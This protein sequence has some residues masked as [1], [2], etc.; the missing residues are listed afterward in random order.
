MHLETLEGVLGTPSSCT[1]SGGNSRYRCATAAAAAG[2]T[3]VHAVVEPCI[4][5]IEA[6]DA[7]R[8]A[9]APLR[10]N[11]KPLDAEEHRHKP[12]RTTDVYVRFFITMMLDRVTLTPL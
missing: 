6:M 5:K 7:R 11:G 1:W 8:W 12:R 9:G 3:Q 2:T 4:V 10:H